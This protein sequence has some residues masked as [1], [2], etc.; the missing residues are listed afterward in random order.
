[1]VTEPAR[2]DTP[3][4]PP[5]AG[6]VQL[7]RALLLVQIG[8]IVTATIESVIVGVAS[9]NLVSLAV[10]NGVFAVWTMFLMRGIGKSSA[11]ARKWTIRLQ[12]G[13]IALAL[14][15][16]LLAILMAD[17]GLEPVPVI[18]R[19]LIPGL[20]IHMLRRPP[21]RYLFGLEPA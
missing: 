20:V 18:T 5:N 13:W 12:V 2:L 19:V 8:I 14:I 4:P 3:P 16:L 17:R 7:V 21:V 15:D 1:M 6:Y 11:R 10:L 9:P